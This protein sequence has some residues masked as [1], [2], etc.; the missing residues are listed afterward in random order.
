MSSIDI[1]RIKSLSVAERVELVEAI[2]DSIVEEYERLPITE[3]QSQ[4]LDNRHAE[5]QKNPGD[6]LTWEQ[7]QDSLDESS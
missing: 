3:A 6:T 1:Q 7:V 5:Y 2:W 4:E